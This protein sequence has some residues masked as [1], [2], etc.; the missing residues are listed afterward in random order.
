MINL[1][2]LIKILFLLILSSCTITSIETVEDKEIAKEV[3]SQEYFKK[4][5]VN[6]SPLVEYNIDF[7]VLEKFVFDERINGNNIHHSKLPIPSV[8]KLSDPK[9]LS[10]SIIVRNIKLETENRLSLSKDIIDQLSLNTN[11]YLEFLK[12]ESI[13]LR[14]V[15]DS[16]EE[17][18]IKMDDTEISFENLDEDQTEISEKLDYEKIKSLEIKNSEKINTILVNIYENIKTAKLK[19]NKIKNLGLLYEENDEGVMVFAGPFPNNDIDLK[20]DFL[21]KNGYINAKKT[22]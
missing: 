15:V 11:V 6:I 20:L 21:I 22:R 16:K 1:N 5:D 8:I 3:P 18:K 7:T 2:N 4:A 9:N 12:D 14:N 10:N 13:I 19:T 17:S